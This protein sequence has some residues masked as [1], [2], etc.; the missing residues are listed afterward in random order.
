ML[1]PKS[2]FTEAFIRANS[3][4]KGEFAAWV[5][6]P[7]MLFGAMQNWWGAKKRRP[8]PHEGIDLCL[9]RD[10]NGKIIGIDERTKVPAA[11][12]GVV[13]K[14][15]DDFLG[16][17]IFVE[18]TFRTDRRSVSLMMYGHAVPAEGLS[19]GEP[20]GKGQVVATVAPRKGPEA[21]VPPHLHVTVARSME[22]IDYAALDWTTIANF[23][24]LQ[25]LDPLE[26]IGGA[27]IMLNPSSTPWEGTES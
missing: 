2:D 17:S 21:R 15:L 4:G 19:V 10:S 3:L 7:D 1:I 16:K 9:F 25:L 5:F 18:H 12:D 6:H 13:V 23:G 8:R 27:H 11:Y 20:V 26:I 22:P 24:G 14:I